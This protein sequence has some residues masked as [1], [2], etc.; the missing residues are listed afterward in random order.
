MSAHVRSRWIQKADNARCV[1]VVAFLL[2][3]SQTS[4]QDD[5]RFRE[6]ELLMAKWRNLADAVVLEATC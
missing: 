2:A 4:L 6:M 3:V 5:A 1:I